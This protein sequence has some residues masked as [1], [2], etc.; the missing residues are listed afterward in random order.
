MA[1][2]FELG[3][4][5]TNITVTDDGSEL[6][7]TSTIQNPDGPTPKTNAV[8]PPSLC[9]LMSLCFCPMS[10]S[11]PE[12][13]KCLYRTPKVGED[14]PDAVPANEIQENLGSKSS[15]PTIPVPSLSL[16]V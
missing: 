4:V 14:L 8:G 6:P 15:F 3:T 9:A 12:D 1:N 11:E 7:L 5:Y 10:D 13:V 16:F 2:D